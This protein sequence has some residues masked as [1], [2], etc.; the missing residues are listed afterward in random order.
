MEYVAKIFA[1]YSRFVQNSLTLPL[2]STEMRCV[3]L[4]SSD[5]TKDQE[6]HRE[7]CALSAITQHYTPHATLA[8]I[9]I[10]ISQ[11]QLFDSSNGCSRGFRSS[12]G[13]RL[14]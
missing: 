13:L 6:E 3:H 14:A 11:L 5:S 12:A 1:T 10:K 9:G 7:R 4:Y 8:A 2:Q